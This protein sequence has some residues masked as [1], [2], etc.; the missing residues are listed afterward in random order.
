MDDQ[1]PSLQQL[2]AVKTDGN[3]DS[4]VSSII[5][6][7]P[8]V[9]VQAQVEVATNEVVTELQEVETEEAQQR[10]VIPWLST[11]MTPASELTTP[12]STWLL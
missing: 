6:P 7:E 12:S 3:N 2:D 4:T 9:N 1:G 8:G 5:L 11:D 10:P